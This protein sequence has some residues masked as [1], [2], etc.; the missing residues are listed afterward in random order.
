MKTLALLCVTLIATTTPNDV[1][2]KPAEPSFA[3][4]PLSHWIKQLKSPDP[5]QRIKA[6]RAIE[7]MGPSAKAA[8]PVLI[9]MVHDQAFRFWAC[10]ALGSIGPEAKEAIPTL[11]KYYPAEGFRDAGAS[12]A[13]EGIGAPAVPVL[14]KKLNDVDREVR[15]S[16]ISSLGRIGPPAKPAIPQLKKAFKDRSARVRIAAAEAAWNIDRDEAAIPIL[17]EALSG[18]QS[19]AYS[20]AEALKKIGPPARASVPALIKTVGHKDDGVRNRAVEALGAMGP[21]ARQAVPVLMAKAG[22]VQQHLFSSDVVSSVSQIGSGAVPALIES[23]QDQ[24][25][26]KAE[27]AATALGRI[28]PDA[29]AAC[30]HLRRILDAEKCNSF[31]AAAALALWRIDKSDVAV[32]SL[33][34][35]LKALDRPESLLWYQALDCLGE[36]GPA[37]KPAVAQL[38]KIFQNEMSYRPYVIEVLGRIGPEAKEAVPLLQP[39]LKD[40]KIDLRVA[41]AVALWKIARHAESVP[42]LTKVMLESDEGFRRAQGA[43]GLQELGIGSKPAIPALIK[44]LEDEDTSVVNHALEALGEHGS[45]AK[46]AIPTIIKL[47]PDSRLHVWESASQALKRIDPTTAR[48][49]GV[50]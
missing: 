32:A 19:D 35:L 10:V 6:L 8:V 42:T 13:L 27:V 21:A 41:A 18:E 26:H 40:E 4:Q 49:A 3:N 34:D 12:I 9:E 44:A 28:G 23:V 24:N 38:I 48:K 50:R 11:L 33:A 17:I 37:A 29:R 16:T 31:R 30:P 22:E 1:G 46:S 15:W 25:K 14:L 39:L 36:L 7:R 20:A 2:E 47:L 5:Y 43:E 45:D